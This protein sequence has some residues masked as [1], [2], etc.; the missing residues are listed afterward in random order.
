MP[1]SRSQSR[2]SQGRVSAEF[3]QARAQITKYGN[4]RKGL[5]YFK[6]HATSA[7]LRKTVQDLA[8]HPAYRKLIWSDITPRTYNRMMGQGLPIETNFIRELEWAILTLQPHTTTITGFLAQKAKLDRAFLLSGTERQDQLLDNFENTFGV[9]LW[10]L[11]TRIIII[12]N[13][14]GFGKQRDFSQSLYSDPNI[15]AIIKYWITWLTLNAETN[16]SARE[17]ANNLS[18]MPRR[19]IFNLVRQFF[20]ICPDV[21]RSDATSLIS[22]ADVFPLVDRYFF[23][24]A[25]VRAF[26]AN[27]LG[28]DILD[29]IALHLAQLAKKISDPTLNRLIIACGGDTRLGNIAASAVH[30]LDLWS[31]GKDREAMDFA[32]SRIE[33]E[34]SIIAMDTYLRAKQAQELDL[35]LPDG[36]LLHQI[37]IDLNSAMGFLTDAAEAYARLKKIAVTYS[38]CAWSA[39]LNLVLSRQSNDERIF[40]AS[41]QQTYDALRSDEESVSFAFC[42]ESL[43]T[44]PTYL[45]ALSSNPLETPSSAAALTLISRGQSTNSFSELT[46]ELRDRLSVALAL[47]REMPK[48]AIQILQPA[49]DSQLSQAK[50]FETGLLLAEAFLQAED[51]IAST[52]VCVTLFLQSPYLGALLPITRLVE[53]LVFADDSGGREVN[54]LGRLDVVIVFDIYSRFVSTARDAERVD[55]FRDFLRARRVHH[56]SEIINS[57]NDLNVE[58]LIYFLTNV[59]VLDMLDQSLALKT[60]RSVE[61][62]RAKILVQASELIVKAGRVPPQALADELQDIRTRQVIRE[63]TFQLDQSKIFVDTGG[64]RKTVGPQLR[65]QWHRYRS[66]ALG[67]LDTE[68]EIF[69]EELKAA[70]GDRVTVLHLDLPQTERNRLFARIVAEITYQFASSKVFGLDANLS[71]NIRHGFILRELR[72]P[73]VTRNLVTN[74]PTPSEGYLKNDQW[75]G[76]LTDT[77]D[78]ATT[79]TSALTRLSEAVDNEIEYIVTR[80]LRV[81]S[82]LVPDGVFD[83]QLTAVQ[84][85]LLEKSIGQCDDFDEFLDGIFQFL[86]TRTERNLEHVRL[87]LTNRSLATLLQ[88]LSSLEAAASTFPFDA[89]ALIIALNATRPEIRSAIERVA[90]WFKLSVSRQY[91]DYS[92]RIAFEAA[93]ATV[94]SYYSRIKIRHNYS[95]AGFISMAGWTLPYFTRIFSIIVENAAV[96]SGIVEG[97]LELIC[98]ATVCDKQ[99]S[100]TV[101]NQ[102]GEAFDLESLRLRIDELNE[103]FGREAASD[104]VRLEGKSGYPKIWKILKHD[105]QRD[106]KLA[107]RIA[108]ELRYVVEIVMNAE[109]IVK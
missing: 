89:S 72:K 56:A 49:F 31:T 45:A 38:T 94:A 48:E 77:I 78:E 35:E 1:K 15:S 2:R 100:I 80:V 25:A 55:A 91:Q 68:V 51:L 30:E 61:D 85:Q 101:T 97:E 76:R 6:A 103:N 23:I 33:N 107:V 40:P 41:H 39:T 10:S 26:V 18:A 34:G 65:E 53:G 7:Q 104:Y 73:F 99:L 79:L 42:F 95:A 13:A 28:N 88:G 20:G 67:G 63:T 5:A 87:V 19:G 62:E 9:S 8:T 32:K 57:A 29:D 37:G 84:I 21:D 106:H 12:Q 50:H 4:V 90:S 58:Q 24:I 105:L 69:N 83:Y 46:S 27:G 47:R 66:L 92:L 82:E 43:G 44:A 96:H 102:M 11:Q 64:I 36:S 54:I 75:I 59:C 52:N 98:L 81:R 74:R 16:V 71:T 14:L 22:F 93:V 3:A 86:F 108:P 70:F 109:D 17:F 60:T